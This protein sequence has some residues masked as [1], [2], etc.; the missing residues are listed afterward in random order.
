MYHGSTRET[1]PAASS[2]LDPGGRG[3]MGLSNQRYAGRIVV[4]AVESLQSRPARSPDRR[5]R[6]KLQN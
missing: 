1:P 2:V 3:T 6:V 4:Y 5:L